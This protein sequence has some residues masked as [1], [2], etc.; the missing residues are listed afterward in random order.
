M[1]F[2]GVAKVFVG[3]IIEGARRIRRERGGVE[4]DAVPLSAEEIL[5]SYRD[6]CKGASDVVGAGA[7]LMGRG[8][9]EEVMGSSGVGG[10]MGGRRR[11]F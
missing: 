10:G 6:Y 4:G 2:G 9:A 7:G 5:E 11:L 8:N 3:E 1:A